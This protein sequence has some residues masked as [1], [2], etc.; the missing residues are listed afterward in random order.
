MRPLI[1]FLFFIFSI[2]C[3]ERGIYDLTLLDLGGNKVSLKRFKG[4]LTLIYIW[5]GTCV[6]H[7]KDLRRLSEFYSKIKLKGNLISIAIMMDTE[8]VREVLTENNIPATFPIFADEKGLLAEEVKITFLPAT[9]LVDDSG[10]VIENR[11]GLSEE[12][13]SSITTHN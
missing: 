1:L 13:L 9:L 7:T 8:G 12:L 10:K 11:P 4:S 5:T 3:W 2:S 6:G